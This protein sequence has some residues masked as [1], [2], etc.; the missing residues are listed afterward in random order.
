MTT[1]LLR[2]I[3]YNS[4]HGR[5]M[6]GKYGQNISFWLFFI[7][8][9]QE[10]VIWAAACRRVTDTV[11]NTLPAICRLHSGKNPYYRRDSVIP[12]SI[13]NTEI[14]KTSRQLASI[15]LNCCIE[16][17]LQMSNGEVTCTVKP[18]SAFSRHDQK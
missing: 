4:T 6:Y 16:N 7:V 11:L 8:F 2:N 10:I 13:P 14:G 5:C 15:S 9:L 1:V 18:A 3:I 12:S 17:F